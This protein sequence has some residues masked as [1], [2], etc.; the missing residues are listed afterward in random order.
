MEIEYEHTSHNFPYNFT[1]PLPLLP[2]AK[3]YN[4]GEEIYLMYVGK[5]KIS[6]I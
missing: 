1:Q 4:R 5:I 6:D 3:I 2:P